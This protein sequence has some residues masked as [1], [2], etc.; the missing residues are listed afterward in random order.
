VFIKG[1]RNT[2]CVVAAVESRRR[3]SKC[4]TNYCTLPLYRGYHKKYNLQVR[5]I[6]TWLQPVCYF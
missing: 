6:Q 2:V 1:S 5:L 4:E 3:L